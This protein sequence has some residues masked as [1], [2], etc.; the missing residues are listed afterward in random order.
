M[1]HGELKRDIL[2]KTEYLLATS[3]VCGSFVLLTSYGRNHVL[4]HNSIESIGLGP[5]KGAM[6]KENPRKP[7]P[8]DWLWE[9][10]ELF[11]FL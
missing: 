2:K 4:T 1:C 11:Y 7:T 8:T 9:K 10:E 5:P 3:T 6:G